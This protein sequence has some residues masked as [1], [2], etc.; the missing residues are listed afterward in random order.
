LLYKGSGGKK[1]FFLGGVEKKKRKKNRCGKF[2]SVRWEKGKLHRAIH[3][4]FR[5]EI[6]Y[7]AYRIDNAPPRAFEID[8]AEPMGFAGAFE[9]GGA[10]TVFRGKKTVTRA[11]TFYTRRI[12][13]GRQR[14]HACIHASSPLI[15]IND[16]FLNGIFSMGGF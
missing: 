11:T 14:T 9:E 12:L 6:F 3:N 7:S 10:A 15:F 5:L 13:W 16:N 1:N 2:N 8:A 4:G